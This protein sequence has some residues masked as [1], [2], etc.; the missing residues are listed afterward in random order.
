MNISVKQ[1]YIPRKGIESLERKSGKATYIPYQ[2][3]LQ[4]YV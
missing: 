1:S 4:L 3:I 2:I